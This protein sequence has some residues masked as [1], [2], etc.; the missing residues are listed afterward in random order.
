MSSVYFLL[1]STRDTGLSVL[2]HVLQICDLTIPSSDAVL[3]RPTFRCG[4][5]EPSGCSQSSSALERQSSSSQEKLN[6]DE[7]VGCQVQMRSLRTWCGG[8]IRE[9]LG[10]RINRVGSYDVIV[11]CVCQ[12]TQHRWFDQYKCLITRENVNLYLFLGK[13][14][15]IS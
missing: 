1:D 11:N 15:R 14:P 12:A 10:S 4:T 13:F 8:I 6:H 3:G 2:R 7:V 5:Y 9:N